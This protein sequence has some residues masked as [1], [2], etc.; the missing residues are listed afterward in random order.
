MNQN[1]IQSVADALLLLN[2]VAENPNKGL[3]ELARIS[4]FNKSRVFRML[5]TLVAQN[6]VY[7][8]SN[9]T[10]QLG[11]QLLVLGQS[12]RSQTTLIQAVEQESE[13]LTQ[14]FNENLQLRIAE[15]DQVVQIWRKV[16]TQA[17]QVRSTVGNKRPMGDGA[18][19]KVLLAYSEAA[20]QAN[21]FAQMPECK[22]ADLQVTLQ[23][24]TAQGFYLSKGELTAEIYAVAVPI[25]DARNYCIAS[26]SLSIPQ[27]RADEQRLA[28]II[29]QMKLAGSAISERLGATH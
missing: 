13:A 22:R 7:Q 9:S 25:F 10:Y 15:N 24:I 2:I 19:G 18:A 6:Y 14:A 11:H 27:S 17:L 8:H 20:Q 3:S 23:Q 26:F 21:F 28:Q 1:T 4:Q 29:S 12:A 5:C 16:S